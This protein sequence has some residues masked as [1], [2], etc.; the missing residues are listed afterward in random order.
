MNILYISEDY[1]GSQ[2]HHNL[3][4]A[5][6]DVD[7]NNNLTVFAFKRTSHSAHDITQTY[8]DLSY[9][10]K[11]AEPKVNQTLYKY[12]FP[13]KIKKKYG[14]LKENIDLCN[15]DLCIAATLFSEGAVA[16]R[17]YKEKQI[18]YIVAVRATDINLYIRKMYHLHK[19]GR[20]ILSN[21]QKVIFITDAIR[22][23][24]FA[25]KFMS[26]IASEIERKSQT[27]TNGIDD[28]W[29]DN[30]YFSEENR[31]ENSIL[32]VGT[33]DSNK[34][35]MRL[36]EACKIAKD[37][38]PDLTLNLIGGKGN[39]ENNVANA[40][41]NCNWIKYHGQ[42]YDKQLL[43][44]DFRKNSIFAMVSHSETF[45]LVYLEALSQGLPI[46]YTSGQGASYMFSKM[47]IGYAAF[48]NDSNDISSKI[49]IALQKRHELA[50][51]I[52]IFPFE[53][54]RWS[55]VAKEWLNNIK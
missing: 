49:D 28:I 17:L 26:P 18:P 15:T 20:E 46:I 24:A 19:L 41:S 12:Y 52:E 9:N 44:K 43:I 48:S 10:L 54:F 16:L 29:I 14:A 2:V 32:Y 7:S 37:K 53:N 42:I 6:H 47:G 39:D 1:I 36:I 4:K 27:I 25:S 8:K 3:C 22:N 23:A 40:I 45:G 30:Q 31:I 50:Q 13:Y 38:Y 5:I 34:N 21:A 33:F 35:V 55:K 51:N 11:I